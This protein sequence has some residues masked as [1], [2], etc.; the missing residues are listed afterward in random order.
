V[1][2]KDLEETVP[3]RID[4][5][6]PAAGAD[7]PA[8][9]PIVPLGRRESALAYTVRAARAVFFRQVELRRLRAQAQ[10]RQAS[11]D[12]S[13]RELAEAAIALPDLVNPLLVRAREGL[14]E[15][16]RTRGELDRK[17]AE[18]GEAFAKEERASR[19]A[20]AALSTE[21]IELARRIEDLEA[22]LRPLRAAERAL[23]REWA[24]ARG[25][26]ESL[27]ARVQSL[28]ERRRAA[29]VR[30]PIDADRAI[31][32]SAELAPLLVERQTAEDALPPL[33]ARLDEL[34]PRTRALEQSLA[35]SVTE[36][37]QG[38]RRGREQKAQR[39]AILTRLGKHLAQVND[40]LARR[41]VERDDALLTL[42]RALDW[43]RVSDLRLHPRYR[44]LD[45]H[46]G[47]LAAIELGL[48][49]LAHEAG[50]LDRKALVRGAVVFA[51]GAAALLALV[52]T[53]VRLG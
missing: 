19:E 1:I 14:G 41:E 45:E 26:A 43:D 32:T 2:A 38:L 28:E 44:A 21:T 10:S 33:R 23:E 8:R 47:A 17:R 46:G 5:E 18:V 50:A 31:E 37:E 12:A 40:E 13:L 35:L 15:I 39:D 29:E 30:G 7:R 36:R 11:R 22:E 4:L 16:E 49:D 27:A 3:R 25:R 6:P 51:L 34:A 42:G 48:A 9:S 53:W 52:W 24:V 20:T